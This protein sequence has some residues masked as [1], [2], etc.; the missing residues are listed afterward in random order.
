M[1][2]FVNLAYGSPEGMVFGLS[3][4]PLRYGLGLEV[5]GGRVV[6]ELKYWPSRSADESGRLVEEFSAITRDALERATDLGARALQLETELSHVATLNPELARSIVEAQESVME[7]YHAEHGIA[8]ALRVTVADV[9]WSREVGREE[10][11][12][13]MLETFEAVAEAGADVLSIESIGGKEVFDYS[14]VRGD[15][16]GVALALAVLSPADVE[17]LWREVASI[18]QRH[19]ALAG[20]DSACGFAN[21]AM[22]LAGGLKRKMLPHVLAAVVRAMSAPRTLKAFEAGARGPGKDCAYENVILKAITGYPISME[23]KSSAA[24]HSSLVGNVAAAAC[25]LWSN[26]QI[27]N[28]RLFGGTGPQ[29]LLEILHYDCELMNAALRAGRGG[30]LRDLLVDSNAFTDPQ[31]LVLTPGAAWEIASSLVAERDDYRRALAAAT[32]ALEVIKREHA[33]GRLALD[34]REAAYARRI[35][36]ELMSL[37]DSADGLLECASYYEERAKFRVSDY[38]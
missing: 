17:R 35:E 10:A 5:G 29:V 2:R 30:A 37:P 11:L 14:L 34:S 23:G 9:R 3:P 7:R 27:E 24:A 31:S 36:R 28:V 33:A 20:G 38:L 4:H 25:D 19:G 8:L 1:P 21:T 22:R 18:A 26:E 6:P 32:R 13:R 12:S 15:L 16:R